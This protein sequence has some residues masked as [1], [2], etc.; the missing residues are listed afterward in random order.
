VG[1]AISDLFLIPW[2][3]TYC[4]IIT[5]ILLYTFYRF[6]KYI[7]ILCV[8]LIGITVGFI[9]MGV[10]HEKEDRVAFIGNYLSNTHEILGEIIKEPDLRDTHQKLTIGNIMIE[11]INISGRVLILDNLETEF[12]YKDKIEV[13]C[14]LEKPEPYE[15]FRYDKYLER[16]KIY[17]IC[18]FPKNIKKTESKSLGKSVLS[19][20]K[21]F[22][23]NIN[24]TLPEPHASLA[25]GILLGERRGISEKL[26]LTFRSV[27][28]THILALSGFNISIIIA[29][30]LFIGRGVGI[31]RTF[32]FWGILLC[33][34]VFVFIT[35]A[36]PSIT[37]AAVMG[38]VVLL[39]YEIGRNT[40]SE[41][42]LLLAAFFMVMVSPRILLWDIGFQ[43]SFM[44]TLGLLVY[45]P[46]IFR[47]S[48][49]IPNKLFARETF[50][51]TISAIIFTLPLS[52][53]YFGGVSLTAL[54]INILIIPL[55]PF[56][57]LFSF[58]AGVFGSIGVI[59]YIFSVPAWLIISAV[60]AIAR[61]GELI[62][63]GYLSFETFSLLGS[64]LLYGI[65]FSSIKILKKKKYDT[66][67]VK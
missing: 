10:I 19:V 36:S 14:N 60:I 3:V 8:I 24:D 54:P 59:T 42:I 4:L 12:M 47:F 48:F 6:Q 34:I 63:Q 32:M 33:L 41:N 30:L 16:F 26:E 17:A 62:P 46:L 27:G 9:R 13:A 31:P 49:F 7:R 40:H 52:M 39:A 11:N 66:I 15:S 45:M 65:I 37:R 55:I 67:R 2:I 25:I 29:A 50:S 38:V 51:A 5:T 56:A 18:P 64:I 43:L 44:A 57:M 1:I 21:N 22:I 20:K 53:Y 61:F 23:Q 58:I 28:I 35:G